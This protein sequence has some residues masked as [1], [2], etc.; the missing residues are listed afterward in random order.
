[1]KRYPREADSAHTVPHI[2]HVFCRRFW[3]KRG[4]P[5]PHRLD[6]LSARSHR[7]PMPGSPSP[8][9]RFDKVRTDLDFPRDEREIL[10]FWK[11]ERIFEKSLENTARSK[12]FV[13]YEGPP[14]ANGLPHNGHV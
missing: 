10:A 5:R 3:P 8:T 13:F 14:T 12:P 9:P 6:P 4:S 1:M 7:A 2:P 11:A